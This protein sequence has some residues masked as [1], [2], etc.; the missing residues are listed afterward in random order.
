M[1]L[2]EL[3]NDEPKLL[4]CFLDVIW[5]ESVV[6]DKVSLVKEEAFNTH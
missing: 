6:T 3:L 4:S 5:P 1:K 2:A